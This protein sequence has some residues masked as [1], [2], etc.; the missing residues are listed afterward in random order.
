MFCLSCSHETG[1]QMVRIMYIMLNLMVGSAICH[2]IIMMAL[3]KLAINSLSF[4]LL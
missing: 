1:H 4:L 3:D 2:N